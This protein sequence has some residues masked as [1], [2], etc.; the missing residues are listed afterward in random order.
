MSD[1]AALSTSPA[2]AAIA[3]APSG[4]SLASNSALDLSWRVVALAN[5][6]RLLLP[7]MLL[8]LQ[9]ATRQSPSVGANNPQL[10]MFACAIY[11]VLGGVVAFGG[12]GRWPSRRVVVVVNVLL[13]TTAICSL[14]Y[15]SG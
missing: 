1:P 13:D 3:G 7:P 12:R 5:I 11:W 8:A 6:Y 15:Y 10:F 4:S 14:L 2:A 9:W